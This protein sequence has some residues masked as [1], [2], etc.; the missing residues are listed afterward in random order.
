MLLN[1]M[2]ADLYFAEKQYAENAPRSTYM[3]LLTKVESHLYEART[4]WTRST[5]CMD[6]QSRLLIARARALALP[7]VNEHKLRI[8]A[9]TVLE[10]LDSHGGRMD[11]KHEMVLILGGLHHAKGNWLQALAMYARSPRKA[12]VTTPLTEV[13]RVCEAHMHAHNESR[14][15]EGALDGWLGAGLAEAA[16]NPISVCRSKLGAA[17]R[18]WC[19][20]SYMRSCLWADAAKE[21][22][23]YRKS[24]PDTLHGQELQSRVNV[25][26][27]TMKE[28]GKLY[29]DGLLLES[30]ALLAKLGR[31][32]TCAPSAILE[33]RAHVMNGDVRQALSSADAAMRHAAVLPATHEVK[34]EAEALVVSMSELREVAELQAGM[35]Q[36]SCDNALVISGRNLYPSTAYQSWRGEQAAFH[37]CTWAIEGTYQSCAERQ[38]QAF[39]GEGLCTKISEPLLIALIMMRAD[40]YELCGFAGRLGTEDRQ[41]QV[42][43]SHFAELKIKPHPAQRTLERWANFYAAFGRAMKLMAAVQSFHE[44]ANVP[45]SLLPAVEKAL[46]FRSKGQVT[47][48][49]HVAKLYLFS[50]ASEHLET[51][52]YAKRLRDEFADYRIYELHGDALR[53]LGKPKDALAQ[54]EKAFRL[55]PFSEVLSAWRILTKRTETKSELEQQSGS[56]QRSHGRQGQQGHQRSHKGTTMGDDACSEA[57][58][59]GTPHEILG[60]S[61]FGCTQQAVKKAFRAKALK[62]HPDKFEGSKACATM[63]FKAIDA[64]RDIL[65]SKCR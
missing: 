52:K 29:E 34:A 23:S 14:V 64:A 15:A 16:C 63:H 2:D 51:T 30:L 41:S 3:H 58:L 43:I 55:L 13:T 39:C 6:L 47:L 21:I 45:D 35:N 12:L 20:E 24:V 27:Q 18:N 9:T 25:E 26:T 59:K 61:R 28:A 36:S 5:V 53:A 19:A 54:Y 49:L 62:Y 48:E 1:E 31:G 57:P 42:Y 37:R 40:A 8:A 50:C 22:I 32:R 11:S 60:V 7:P 65:L 46:A 56:R 4:C 33:A 17:V 38:V 44:C 10:F